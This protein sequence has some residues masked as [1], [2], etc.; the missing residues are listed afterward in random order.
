MAHTPISRVGFFSSLFSVLCLCSQFC[1]F[2]FLISI[3]PGPVR[4][5][6]HNA[7]LHFASMIWVCDGPAGVSASSRGYARGLRMDL[8]MTQP[9]LYRSL[10]CVAN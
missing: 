5:P 10:V 6:K 4:Q 8:S 3:S 7:W 9:S 2:C 1:D